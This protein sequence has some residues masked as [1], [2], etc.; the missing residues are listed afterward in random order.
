MSDSRRC[1]ADVFI[2]FSR[3]DA[4]VYTNPDP[5]AAFHLF[6]LELRVLDALV[7]A[8]GGV[9]R[10]HQR[11]SHV[12]RR[13]PHPDTVLDDMQ[14]LLDVL[15][16]RS[17]PSGARGGVHQGRRRDKNLHLHRMDC[18]DDLCHHLQRNEIEKL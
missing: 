4:E 12:V 1:R 6:G 2:D 13:A 9:K 18:P 8:R 14:L 15:R 7:Q 3:Q 11:E 17:S 5:H 10:N 16:R